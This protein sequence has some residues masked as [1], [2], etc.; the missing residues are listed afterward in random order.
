M[1]KYSKRVMCSECPFRANA[2]KGWLG[3]L[4]ADDVNIVVHSD[5][6]YICHVDMDKLASEGKGGPDN[7]EKLGEHCVGMAR[8]RQSVCKRPRDPEAA[9]FQDA[10]VKVADKPIIAPFQFVKYHTQEST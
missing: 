6:P 10:V 5:L 4:S 9:A 3:P 2:L 7:L 8:Y 1:P